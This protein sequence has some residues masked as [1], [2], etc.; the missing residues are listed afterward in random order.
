MTPDIR[1][2]DV[3]EDDLPIFF[4]HQLDSD[5]TRMAGFPARDREAF[6][7]HWTKIMGDE[8]ITKKTILFDGQ[9][10]GNIV[11]F[12]QSGEPHVGYWIGKPY[13][14]KGVATKALSEFLRHVKARPL[15]AHVV[16]DNIASIRVLEKCGFTISSEEVEE[17]ILRLEAN[18]TEEAR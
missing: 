9:V 14:G 12:E 11:S 4:E 6:M 18:V 1:L 17:V 10:A 13:W 3:T 7:A 2:R 8:R 15:Y 16:K 5:A